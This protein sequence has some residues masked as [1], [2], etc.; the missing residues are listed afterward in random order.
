LAAGEAEGL[1]DEVRALG[2]STLTVEVVTVVD[3]G[4]GADIEDRE[5]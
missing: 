2:S 3:S 5:N 4:R 1:R